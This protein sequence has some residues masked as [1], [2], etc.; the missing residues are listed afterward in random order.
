M[1]RTSISKTLRGLFA[2]FLVSVIVTQAQAGPGPQA[3]TPVKTAKQAESIK[4][5]D[6]IAFHCGNCG[7]VTVLTVDKERS[8]LRGYTCPKCKLKFV[9]HQVGGQG[10]S[11]GSYVYEDGAGHSAKL[12]RAM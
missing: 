2:A 11:V 5:G 10:G 8:F 12:L 6:R 1:N 7:T 3:F 4:E 9:M